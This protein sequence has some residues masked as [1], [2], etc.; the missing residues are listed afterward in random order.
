[1]PAEPMLLSNKEADQMCM[2][3]MIFTSSK[4]EEVKRLFRSI[5][6]HS[7]RRRMQARNVFH[8]TVSAYDIN[9][10]EL[11]AFACVRWR[12]RQL[13]HLVLLGEYRNDLVRCNSNFFSNG[14]EIFTDDAHGIVHQSKCP[15]ESDSIQINV[16][17]QCHP[18]C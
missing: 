9:T 11:L 16:R 10:S 8:L 2:P 12:R 4:I 5:G 6:P 18:P 13:R 17:A 3:Y 14:V 7:P 1:M 15:L